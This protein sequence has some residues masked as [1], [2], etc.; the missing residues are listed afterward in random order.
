MFTDTPVPTVTGSLTVGQTLTAGPGTW[1]PGPA[2]LA[3]QWK[4]GATAITG[5]TGPTYVLAGDDLGQ[6]MTVTVTAS[7]PGFTSVSRTSAATA[8]VAAANLTSTPT[9]TITGTPVVGAKLT[10]VPGAWSPA[11]VGLEYQWR[12]NG[13]AIDGADGK[14][15]VLTADDLTKRITVTVTGS[16]LG[17]I[18]ASSTSAQTAL[19]TAGTLSSTPVPTFTG[20]PSVGQRLTADAGTWGPAPVYLTYQWMR[21]GNPITGANS[22]TFDL[23]VIDFGKQI[24]VNVKGAKPGFTTGSQTSVPSPAVGPGTLSNTPTPTISGTPAV[25]RR[26]TMSTGA[27]SPAPVALTYQWLR[28]G[29]AITDATATSYVLKAEDLGAQITVRVQ[30]TKMPMPR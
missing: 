30:G 15:Y 1:S 22:R 11:P 21:D 5:A 27:W 8:T 16:R 19:V 10:T 25:G 18:S 2:V 29:V 9:P 13:T 14:S 26:L 20:T 6:T 28:D 3:Y 4:R 12:R 7:R 24:S 23:T 17:Y